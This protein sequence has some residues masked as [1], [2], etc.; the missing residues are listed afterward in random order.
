M[1]LA[2]VAGHPDYTSSGASNYIPELWAGKLIDKFYKTTVFGAISNTN[3][4]GVIKNQGDKVY[5]RQIGDVT[6]ND[7]AKG[8][9]LT[10]ERLESTDVELAID[11]GKYFAFTCDDVDAYQSDIKLMNEWS[12]D[13]SEQ[14]KIAIDS[15]ILDGIS[16]SSSLNSYNKGATAGA[17]SASY[18]LGA[19][20]A[21]VQLTKANVI[22]YIVDCGTVLDEQNVPET[23]R[24]MVIPSWIANL[25]KKSD[26]KDAS[27]VGESPT[28]L[29]NGRLGVID[30]FTLYLSNNIY[31]AT[32]TVTCY[33][34]LFGT[35]HAITF[36]SQITK[37]ETL[38]A[39]TTFGDLVR[40][41]QVYGFE[42]V[43]P[44]ALGLLYCRK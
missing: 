39:E 11:K 26:L 16:V 23:G 20:T 37:M 12:T 22:E 32:D 3:Y 7:Y 10:Y 44:E 18:N 33:Y 29:R 17:I 14:M 36:A 5:I 41:L 27:L 8:Q 35:N 42:L 25:I 24:W 2:R 21:P 9:K 38:R 43:K 34:V 19:S 6:I 4:Q 28:I 40:G 15:D 1:S 30:R 31:S 13:A